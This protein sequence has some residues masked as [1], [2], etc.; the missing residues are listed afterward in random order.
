M[1]HGVEPN[2][3]LEKRGHLFEATIHVLRAGRVLVGV[4]GSYS[5]LSTA[6]AAGG[7][8]C[9]FRMRCG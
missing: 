5:W 8:W 1:E 9:E 3:S 4:I 7:I 2:A 6:L